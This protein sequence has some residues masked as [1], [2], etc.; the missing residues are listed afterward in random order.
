MNNLK[1]TRNK[2]L[3]LIAINLL[4]FVSAHTGEEES[5]HHMMD[6]WMASSWNMGIWGIFSWIFGILIIV[7]LVFFIIWLNKQIQKK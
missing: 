3:F 2:I 6:G 1:V 5:G 7:A 4:S